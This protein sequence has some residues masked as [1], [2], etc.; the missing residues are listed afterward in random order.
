MDLC[1]WAHSGQCGLLLERSGFSLLPVGKKK[2]KK[3]CQECPEWNGRGRWALG[4]GK[5]TGRPVLSNCCLSLLYLPLCELTED[6]SSRWP[7][8]SPLTG[9]EYKKPDGLTEKQWLA[10]GSLESP[11][12]DDEAQLQ[13]SQFAF[14]HPHH[15]VQ[16]GQAHHRRHNQ[17]S[18]YPLGRERTRLKECRPASSL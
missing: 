17:C 12:S 11:D 1:T 13:F 10:A 6:G 18:Q 4:S 15:D 14:H 2:N 8:L 3:Q 5:S 16:L 7:W 9:A